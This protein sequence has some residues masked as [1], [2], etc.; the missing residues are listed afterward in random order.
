MSSS[1]QYITLVGFSTTTTTNNIYVSNNYAQTWIA[2]KI[3]GET[4]IKTPVI[5]L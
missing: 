1:G 5:L 2:T 4:T 3:S